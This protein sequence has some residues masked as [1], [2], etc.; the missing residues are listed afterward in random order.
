MGKGKT[1]LSYG[2][3]G[4]SCRTTFSPLAL[5]NDTI[6]LEIDTFQGIDAQ[7][8]TLDRPFLFGGSDPIT[9]LVVTRHGSINLDGSLTTEDGPIPIKRGGPGYERV[10]RIQVAQSTYSISTSQSAGIYW[11][12][13]GYSNIISWEPALI[14]GGRIRVHF[15]AELFDNGDIAMTWESPGSIGDTLA[16]SVGIEGPD[17]VVVAPTGFPFQEDG[18][19]QYPSVFSQDF[20]LRFRTIVQQTPVP[21]PRPTPVP[22]SL[23][24]TAPTTAPVAPTTSPAPSVDPLIT[25]GGGYSQSSSRC[26]AVASFQELSGDASS[27]KLALDTSQGI[28]TESVFLNRPFLFKGQ[29]SITELVVTAYG[30]INLDGSTLFSTSTVPV[31]GGEGATEYEETARIQVAQRNWG[32][33]SFG[34][35]GV[36][37]KDTGSSTIVSWE[38]GLIG[39]GRIQQRFQVELYDNGDVEM[40]WLSGGAI[41][42]TVA[43][44]V[45]IEDGLGF[46]EPGTGLPFG[47]EGFAQFPSVFSA[48][49]CRL[50]TVRRG[51]S[52]PNN[53]RSLR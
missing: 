21:S 37:L 33:T 32:V 44:T 42:D 16:V 47:E 27:T 28:A 8:I 34:T 50:F 19:S 26:N 10:P 24:I 15:Q 12:D 9:T 51:G 39:G 38:P 31:A 45:G 20:C 53:R 13:T 46:V 41:G 22:T 5:L 17:N 14:A 23:P 7:A 30:S 11:R 25:P 6:K 40:R 49:T 18:F 48:D 2:V 43:V 35:S 52:G 4:V 36:F 29:D 1:P 3:D